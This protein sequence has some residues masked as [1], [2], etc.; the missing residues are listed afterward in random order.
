MLLDW[1]ARL[2]S[3]LEASFNAHP[4][5]NLDMA[6]SSCA[7]ALNPAPVAWGVLAKHDRRELC[8]RVG[9]LSGT[10]VLHS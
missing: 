9:C 5:V 4:A 3:V 1:A 2:C 7:P 6:L 10:P 8:R